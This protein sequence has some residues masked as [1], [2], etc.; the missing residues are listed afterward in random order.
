VTLTV[1]ATAPDRTLALRLAEQ[2]ELTDVI[3]HTDGDVT[4]PLEALPRLLS[5]RLR[6]SDTDIVVNG[7]VS[8]EDLR[9]VFPGY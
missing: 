7:P 4:L 2:A 9:R 3:S 5:G 8:L 1:R 6:T